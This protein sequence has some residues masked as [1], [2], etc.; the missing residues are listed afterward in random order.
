MSKTKIAIRAVKKA[1]RECK[2]NSTARVNGGVV[3]IC[4]GEQPLFWDEKTG[5]IR[6][7]NVNYPA[8]VEVLKQVD[9]K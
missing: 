2:I 7:L 4:K 9:G 1:I 6:G 3:V 8:D 5:K